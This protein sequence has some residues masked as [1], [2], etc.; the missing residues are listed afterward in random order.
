MNIG[1]LDVNVAARRMKHVG[2]APNWVAAPV[3]ILSEEHG[4]GKIGEPIREL[5]SE[6]GVDPVFVAG[7]A[8]TEPPPATG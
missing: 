7:I 5:V 3:I 1:G 6:R 2:P 8:I 4:A